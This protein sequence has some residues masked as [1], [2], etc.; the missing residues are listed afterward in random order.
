MNGKIP[1]LIVLITL[2]LLS[3][4]FTFHSDES[5]SIE[6]VVLGP[7]GPTEGVTVRVRATTNK[8]LSA[9]DGSFKL[10][11][12]TEDVEVEIT[13]WKYGYYI[14]SAH[15]TPTATGVNLT[16]RPYH[17]IDNPEYAWASPLESGT[18]GSCINCH[19]MIINEW[20]NNA[21]GTAVENPRFYSMYNGTDVLGENTGSGY[22]VDFPGTSGNCANCHAPGAGVD[23]YL[24]TDMNT[25]KNKVTA[26]IHCDYCHKIGGVYLNPA[27]NSVYS[28]TPGVRSQ[29][30]LRPPENDNIFFG[31]YDDIHDPDTYLP[32]ISESSF[33]APCHQFS[34][35]GT[36]I[37]E[38]YNEWLTSPYQK[39]GVT[40][41]DCH[42]PPNGAQFFALPEV[43]GLAHP[44]ELI[45]SHLQVGAQ[46]QELLES[47]VSL[48]I[49]VASENDE[50][51]VK[52]T[53]INTGAGHHVPTDYP[54]RQMIL[55]IRAV[56]NS[57]SGLSQK[58]GSEIP[59]WG[60]TYQGLPGTIYAKVLRDVQ[61]GEFPVVTYWKQTLI[62]SDNRIA[63]L[64]R[65]TTSYGFLL[66]SES[67]TV[68]VTASIYFRRVF[69]SVNEEKKWGIPD[70]LMAEST[71]QIEIKQ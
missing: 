24:S 47:T 60:G 52:A 34:M 13:A 59:V 38:S 17:T 36:P 42:M 30:V 9:N 18:Q 58:S 31:P 63:A 67:D 62:E 5:G 2:S 4:G 15:F 6:G 45:P 43:G 41:Q 27:T 23:G 69:Q 68:T 37:Y 66:P 33:C 3:Y 32:E 71:K 64:D 12:L 14:A 57:G 61:T 26:G 10:D 70:I 46:D 39:R 21:H 65:D 48:D 7:E 40:C 22:V 51:G 56:D 20:K 50:I 16:L 19:P 55:V 8:V 25:V 35:W 28:N 11:G 1:V 53:I 44:P 54:G 29:K 49:E